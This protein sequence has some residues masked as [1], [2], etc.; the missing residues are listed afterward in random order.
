MKLISFIILFIK[1]MGNYGYL[2]SI[3]IIFY[4]L[5]FLKVL[6]NIN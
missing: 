3:K 1:N 5:I 2:N 6:K 4:E